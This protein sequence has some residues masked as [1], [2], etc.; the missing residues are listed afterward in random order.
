MVPR[1]VVALAAA[2]VLV[3][4]GSGGTVDLPSDPP[5][6][7]PPVEP[8]PVEPPPV[9]PPPVEPPPV[10]P[11]PVEPPPSGNLLPDPEAPFVLPALQTELPH[12]ELEVASGVLSALDSNPRD[13]VL[14]PAT[15]RIDGVSYPV[16]VRY[17]GNSSRV[18]PKKS[19]RVEFAKENTFDGRHKL[20]LLS[21]WRDQ[22]MMVEKLGYDL[23]AAMGGVASKA[24]YVRLSVNGVHQGVYLDLERVDKAFL[25]AH[26]FADRDATIYR[27]PR[28]DCEMKEWSALFQGTWEKKT[29]ELV[30]GTADL[31]AFLRV[32]HAAPESDL[33]AVLGQ[34]FEL[35]LYLRTMVA[36]A[37]IS[38]DTVEDSKSYLIHDQITGRWHYAPWDFNNST[39]KYQP[40]SNPGKT[41]DFDQPLFVFTATNTWAQLEYERRKSADG[42]QDWHAMFSDLATRIQFHPETRSRLVARLEQAL[43][44]LFTAEILE[45]RIDAMHALIAPH[46]AGDPHVEPALFADA[47]RYLKEFVALRREFLLDELARLRASGPTVLLEEVD[48]AAGKVVLKNYGSAPVNLGGWV[49]TSNLRNRPAANLGAKT[50]GPGETVELSTAG[51]GPSPGPVGE[52]GLW[53]SP[54]LPD[55]ADLLFLGSLEPGQRWARDPADPTRWRK[56]Q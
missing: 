3:S 48:P 52:I 43:D 46:M 40:G 22:S 36:E 23:L 47:P 55:V 13:D 14:Y 26:Q 11:P 15:F 5:P 44:T 41:A 32:I 33:P 1:I 29:N 18:W 20:N 37:L 9:E 34:H 12:Y 35:E 16:Q 4:C 45:P 53:R 38:N 30:P 10:E 50:L 54:A 19:W 42:S 24:T 56:V 6:E 8:P 28:K 49:L 31:D 2:M 7:K 17:R 51:L 27:C 21:E 25:V 39:T